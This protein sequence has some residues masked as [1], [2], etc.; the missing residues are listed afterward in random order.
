MTN[1]LKGPEEMV[2]PAAG[3]DKPA[4]AP[5]KMATPGDAE[6]AAASEKKEPT[7]STKMD[8]EVQK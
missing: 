2:A 1:A 4:A 8:K 7:E 3:Q 5:E 6:G